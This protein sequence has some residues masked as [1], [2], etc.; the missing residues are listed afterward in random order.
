MYA[1]V[2]V[3]MCMCRCMRVCM[4]GCVQLAGLGGKGH[5]AQVARPK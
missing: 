3:C 1:W 5:V 2:S 4:H